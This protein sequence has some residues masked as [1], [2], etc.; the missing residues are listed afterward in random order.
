[1]T[2]I[3][4]FLQVLDDHCKTPDVLFRGQREDMPLLPRIARVTFDVG[5]NVV[6][7]EKKMFADFR[8]QAQ[9]HLELRPDNDWDWL[10]LAQHHGMATRLLDWTSNPLA[11]MWFAV[12]R[13]SV[14]GLPAVIWSL[15]VNSTDYVESKEGADPWNVDRTR[16]FR[17]THI[18]RRII[19]QNGWF[20]AHRFRSVGSFLA[21]DKNSMYKRRLRRILVPA[22]AFSDLRWDLDRFG[23]N[24]ASL[25]PDLDG[26]SRYVEWTHSLASDEMQSPAGASPKRTGA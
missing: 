5:A 2:S 11:A 9:P 7:V 12:Q 26:V 20:T 1:M 3:R 21:L 13:P 16:V 10:A 25:F 6:D 23:I 14:S 18:T 8:R 22:A 15:T 24:A 17:P 19:A 4:G